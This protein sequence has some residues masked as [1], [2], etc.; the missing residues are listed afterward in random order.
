MCLYSMFLIVIKGWIFARF[1]LYFKIKKVQ[2]L[3][4]I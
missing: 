1:E 4:F 2:K 3:E